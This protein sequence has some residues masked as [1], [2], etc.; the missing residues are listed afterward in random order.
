MSRSQ[1]SLV[2]VPPA[3]ASLLLFCT[4]CGAVVL[5]VLISLALIPVLVGAGLVFAWLAG[6]VLFGW[7][8]IEGLAALERWFE[9]DTRFHR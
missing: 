2:R 4:A 6:L 9:T 1:T 8:A 7:A 5:A 3:I